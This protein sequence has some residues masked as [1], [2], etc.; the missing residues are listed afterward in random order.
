M[1]PAMLTA[2]AEGCS[3]VCAVHSWISYGSMGEG[4]IIVSKTYF[5]YVRFH[6][7]TRPV[8]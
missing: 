2:A 8:T 7:D 1:L 5:F 4:Y 6:A 3:C